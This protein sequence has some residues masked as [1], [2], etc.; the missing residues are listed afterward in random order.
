MRTQPCMAHDSM[1]CMKLLNQD[2][3]HT[4]NIV[5]NFMQILPCLSTMTSMRKCLKYSGIGIHICVSQL[6]L[7]SYLF[8]AA[9]KSL[10]SLQI[11]Q[12]NSSY[13]D[14]QTYGNG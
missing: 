6:M 12:M 7:N 10:K 3:L 1:G 2:L 9:R 11:N 5:E 13:K 4:V 8:L 14:I